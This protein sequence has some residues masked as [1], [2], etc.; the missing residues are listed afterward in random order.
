MDFFT[1]IRKHFIKNPPPVEFHVATTEDIQAIFGGENTTGVSMRKISWEE[2][3]ELNVIRSMWGDESADL[4]SQRSADVAREPTNAEAHFEL[5]M[6][7]YD[8]QLLEQA[9]PCL[10]M[11]TVLQPT[12]ADAHHFLGHLESLYM[13]DG[14][15][16]ELERLGITP[17]TVIAHYNKAIELN[18][19][20]MQYALHNRGVAHLVNDHRELARQDLLAAEKLGNKAA[21]EILKQQF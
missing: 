11:A 10:E 15:D 5:G 20:E 12:H 7:Y 16:A 18:T 6:F 21:G 2:Y 4:L 3:H 13:A 8:H 9:R 17:D 19:S 14:N 1:R